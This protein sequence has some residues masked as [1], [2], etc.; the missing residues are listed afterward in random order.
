MPRYYFDMR[1]A[2][3]VV[4]DE[5]GMELGTMKAV[6]QEAAQAVAYMAR[7]RRHRLRIAAAARRGLYVTRTADVMPNA[8]DD[9]C[10]KIVQES[11]ERAGHAQSM[12]CDGPWN[13][14]KILSD[15]RQCALKAQWPA[16]PHPRL[17]RSPIGIWNGTSTTI[18][19]RNLICQ[20]ATWCRSGADRCRR[21][22][23]KSTPGRYLIW[24]FELRAW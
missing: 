12:I 17:K 14:I 7:V 20:K 11:E 3:G 19:G 23:R 15:R 6:Q 13:R 21:D 10:R 2:D 16:C 9:G 1:D 5:E 8:P 18:H 4:P 22:N 24:S